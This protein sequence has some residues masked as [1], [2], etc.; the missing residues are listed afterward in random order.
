MDLR[1]R[2]MKLKMQFI[3]IAG[4]PLLGMLGIFTNGLISF[5]SLQSDMRYLTQ[6]NEERV[7]MVNAD[8]DA[9]QALETEKDA[10]ATLSREKL[11]KLD[12]ENKE[13]S[14]TDLGQD[15]GTIRKFYRRNAE[16]VQP[17]QV[18]IP[19]LGNQQ[20][21]RYNPINQHGRPAHSSQ[22]P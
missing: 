6:F 9:Y 17:V 7:S 14:Q 2:R 11:L 4:L 20:P 16:T 12:E 18:G 22:K 8:R 10:M 21:C 13:K 5:R 3:L 15:A 19:V 1:R